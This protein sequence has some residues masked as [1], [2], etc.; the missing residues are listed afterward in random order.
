[1]FEHEQDYESQWAA[2]RSI[3]EKVGHDLRDAA[4]VGAPGGA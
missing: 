4:Q 2:I 1:V 3:A